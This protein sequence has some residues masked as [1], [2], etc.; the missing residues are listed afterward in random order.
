MRPYA[1]FL[2]YLL[3]ALA[4][5]LSV[6]AALAQSVTIQNRWTSAFLADAGGV[7]LLPGPDG[8]ATI[9]IAEL[10][11]GTDHARLRNAA[12]GN[13]LHVEYGV[14]QAGPVD[15]GWWS[16]MWI[17]ESVDGQHVR[18]RNRFRPDQYL[19]NETGPV[20]AAA[21]QPG[22]YSAMWIVAPAG[23]PAPAGA[24]PVAAAPLPQGGG[25]LPPAQPAAGVPLIQLYV[26]NFSAAP[27]DV[28]LDVPNADPAYVQ[29]VGPGQQ[30][31]Q[32]APPETL[33]ALAQNDEWVG[34]YRLSASAVQV[35]RYREAAR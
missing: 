25:A 13:Y 28:F 30:L 32:M 14:L 12:S 29:T 31:V 6:P 22:W 18:I 26:Q 10:V 19:T 24:A 5:G 33:W 7:A 23:G 35:I 17:Q 8:Q 20:M 2:L 9:W 15:P 3:A 16:A 34:D 21:V 1:S 11:E 27:I 4:L